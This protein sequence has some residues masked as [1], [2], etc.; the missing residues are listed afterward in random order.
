MM[1]RARARRDLGLT[2]RWPAWALA[3]VDALVVALVRATG[4]IDPGFLQ[5][6]I[7]ASAGLLGLLFLCML[8]DGEAHFAINEANKEMAGVRRGKYFRSL[9]DPVWGLFG[10][11]SGGV[12]AG[13]MRLILLA[14]FLIEG[15]LSGS[16]G[17][18]HPRPGVGAAL[19][20]GFSWP[21]APP[22]GVTLAW[23]GLMLTLAASLVGLKAFYPRP[24]K[25][26]PA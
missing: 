12:L 5:A 23:L 10:S 24:A 21:G 6:M 7:I 17:G 15:Y 2:L 8:F 19:Y 16:S 9:V 13:W 18:S 25:T 20:V 3:I 1:H 11:R 4:S 22:Q 14:E 26:S